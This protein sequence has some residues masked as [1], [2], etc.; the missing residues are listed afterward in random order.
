M[1]TFINYI[2]DQNTI[3]NNTGEWNTSANTVP[4]MSVLA[5]WQAIQES[6]CPI[7]GGVKML[8]IGYG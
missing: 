6:Q 2:V 4:V 1:N 7:K 5:S 3:T 8:Q